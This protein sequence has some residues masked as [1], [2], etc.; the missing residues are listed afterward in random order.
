MV[1]SLPKSFSTEGRKNHAS[2]LVRY[3][4]YYY[5]TLFIVIWR[6]VGQG[7]SIKPNAFLSSSSSARYREGA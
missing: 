1:I 5:K 6:S 2:S 7:L 3:T 4:Y